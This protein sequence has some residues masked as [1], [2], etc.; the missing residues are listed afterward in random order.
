MPEIPFH[1]PKIQT[2]SWRAPPGPLL[3]FLVF[4]H[5]WR[6]NWHRRCPALGNFNYVAP[7]GEWQCYAIVLS[8]WKCL[9][10]RCLQNKDVVDYSIGTWNH[11][12]S[13]FWWTLILFRR[14]LPLPSYIVS[15]AGFRNG[16]AGQLPR[17]LHNQ[18][19]FTY[20]MKKQFCKEKCICECLRGS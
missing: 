17:G 11:L 19:V 15:R 12:F 8:K 9:H 4:A 7:S 2:F 18:G 14:T 5:G 20:F 6:S 1:S 3:A 13:L 16:Q 10:W